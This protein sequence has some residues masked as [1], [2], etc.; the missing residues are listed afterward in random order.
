MQ[1]IVYRINLYLSTPKRPLFSLQFDKE[2][3]IL[4]HSFE[5]RAY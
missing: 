4:E 1:E 3:N 5:R 2:Q